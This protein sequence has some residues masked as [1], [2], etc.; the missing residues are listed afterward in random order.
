MT[1]PVLRFWPPRQWS[2]IFKQGIFI[3]VLRDSEHATPLLQV[4][5]RSLGKHAGWK[6]DIDHPA[7]DQVLPAEANLYELNLGLW[8]MYLA[9][10]MSTEKMSNSNEK[11]GAKLQAEDPMCVNHDLECSFLGGQTYTHIKVEFLWCT[12]YVEIVDCCLQHDVDMWCGVNVNSIEYI[13]W[14][15]T[16]VS[17]IA[18]VT[19]ARL[20]GCIFAKALK[21]ITLDMPWY[22]G[23]AITGA[24][25][26]II[27]ATLFSLGFYTVTYFI[28]LGMAGSERFP[29][30][31]RHDD[32][33]L[34]GGNRHTIHCGDNCRNLCLEAGKPQDCYMC[35][36]DCRYE[37]GQKIGQGKL[38]GTHFFTDPD[39]KKLCCPE[40]DTKSKCQKKEE[41]VM[42]TCSNCY[43]CEWECIIAN[44]RQ[45][46]VF[47]QENEFNLPCCPE[48]IVPEN[49]LG[50]WC[51]EKSKT[52]GVV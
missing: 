35:Y 17:E 14:N 8:A 37:K 25:L 4:R 48:T 11:E 2:P 40:T 28:A 33:C 6:L 23:G 10:R 32:S 5:Y 16:I 44:G 24:I 47:R 45:K 50:D 41:D 49:E 52:K 21:G 12:F 13:P 22:C 38:I 29:L 20:L 31:G 1:H 51:K 7:F 36:W 19:S 39:G 30:D 15:G 26:G 9:L 34:C 18:K 3:A 46:R 42:K 43:P 27:A